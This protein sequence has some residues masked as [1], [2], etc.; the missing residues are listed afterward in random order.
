VILGSLAAAA[1]LLL[2]LRRERQTNAGRF[3]LLSPNLLREDGLVDRRVE[4]T[5]LVE[6]LGVAR[7]VARKHAS[8]SQPGEPSDAL[9]GQ[10]GEPARAATGQLPLDA[11]VPALAD[12]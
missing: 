6:K 5:T 9:T 8:A 11:D 10:T 12:A 7:V 1:T 4:L 2:N 3:D